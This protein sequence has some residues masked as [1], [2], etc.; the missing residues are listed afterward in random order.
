MS[1][2][3]V[4]SLMSFRCDYMQPNQLFNHKRTLTFQLDAR[5]TDRSRLAPRMPS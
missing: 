4:V 5:A 1:N 3:V 2:R